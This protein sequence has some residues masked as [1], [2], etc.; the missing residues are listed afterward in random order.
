MAS[1]SSLASLARCAADLGAD[2][3]PLLDL[4]AT[5]DALALVVFEPVP[6]AARGG[7]SETFFDEAFLELF[8][9]RWVT[10]FLALASATAEGLSFLAD[11]F[12]A[13]SSQPGPSHMSPSSGTSSA[14]S[15]PSTASVA[16]SR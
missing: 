4:G 12:F 10:G 1:S 14:T 13:A 7:S 15:L 16:S 8:L 3:W 5:L 9:E 2:L 11:S 6:A